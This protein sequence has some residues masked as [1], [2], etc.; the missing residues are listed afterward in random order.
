[1]TDF[2]KNVKSIVF[3]L[4]TGTTYKA[5][6][7][8][9]LGVHCSLKCHFY[10]YFVNFSTLA[11]LSSYFDSTLAWPTDELVTKIQQNSIYLVPTENCWYD[12]EGDLL[13]RYTCPQSIT[14][15]F[16]ERASALPNS[17]ITEVIGILRGFLNDIPYGRKWCDLLKPWHIN[18]VMLYEFEEHPENEKWRRSRLGERILSV[19]T[20]LKNCL[21]EENCMDYFMKEKNLM[22]STE[23]QERS[24]TK[25]TDVLLD[26]NNFF[27]DPIKSV[28]GLIEDYEFREACKQVS[29]L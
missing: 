20:R 16:A 7:I 21:Q 6:V 2:I 15:L 14:E 28:T 1:M 22:S 10:R 19:M 25:I 24:K 3:V 11:S 29:L 12:Q 5:E 27:E 23:M 18:A 17:C 13:W 9:S 4:I 8:G 26:I